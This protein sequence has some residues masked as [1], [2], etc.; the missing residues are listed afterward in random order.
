MS[1]TD[2][3]KKLILAAASD[4]PAA[5]IMGLLA[6]GANIDATDEGGWCSLHRALQ[7]GGVE[8]CA[9]LLANGANPNVGGR[10]GWSAL[11]WA[12]FGQQ[13]DACLALIAAGADMDAKNE[14]GRSALTLAAALGYSKVC[15]A[16]IHAGASTEGF[17]ER[18]TKAGRL[19]TL[20]VGQAA[21]NEVAMRSQIDAPNHPFGNDTA[22]PPRR[23]ISL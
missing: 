23:R 18:C 11:H 6:K 5:E 7:R 22:A 20:A 15:L 1:I 12:A 14:N 16:L 4:T 9:L 2:I 17:V 8:T 13:T 19:E 10:G 21:I 3:D